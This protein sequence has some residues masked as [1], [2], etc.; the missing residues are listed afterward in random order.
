MINFPESFLMALIV[1]A[2]FLIAISI[3]VLLTLL[4]MDIKRKKLW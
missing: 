2:L 1:G 3:G 4:Y